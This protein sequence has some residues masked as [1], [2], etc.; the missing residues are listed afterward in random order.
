MDGRHLH[1]KCEALHSVLNDEIHNLVINEPPGSCKSML[2]NVFLPAYIWLVEDPA[3]RMLFAS[4]SKTLSDRDAGKVI[5]LLR[6]PLVKAAYPEFS[7]GPDK[8]KKAAGN[9]Y[10]DHG[11]HRFN[12]STPGGQLTGLHFHLH[13][14][15][16]PIKPESVLTGVGEEFQTAL[17][18]SMRWIGNTAGSRFIP[19]VDG[20]RI[21]MMQR[22]HDADPAGR[23]LQEG[24]W[25]HLCFPEE[26]VPG[27]KWIRGDLTTKLE[28]RT[29]PG[30][31]LWPERRDARKLARDK[32]A[33]GDAATVSAQLQQNPTPDSGGILERKWITDHAYQTPPRL[34]R[35]QLAASFDFNFK[36]KKGSGSLAK[37]RVGC[38]LWA[39]YEGIYYLIAAEALHTGY[40]GS[41]DL[42][43]RKEADE[44]WAPAT[45]LIEAKANGPAVEED[46]SEEFS[47]LRL[48]EP[49]S[50]GKADR[51]A[52]FIEPIRRGEVRFPDPKIYPWAEEVIDEIVKF[53]RAQYDE[54]WDC[55]TQGLMYLKSG[56]RNYSEGLKKLRAAGWA[57]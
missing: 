20:K 12:A 9:F 32:K 1:A 34:D 57:V 29:E 39:K 36:E 38:H 55:A 46:L 3:H 15:D 33:M 19:S 40:R 52:P 54:H 31:L 45:F 47:N 35:C 4:Y 17:N 41:K 49:G 28:W 21:L 51:M 16:D 56:A 14:Y 42:I 30:E 24:G 26:Y 48:Y 18:A 25:E 10:N 2:L 23:L 13:V 53:P 22:L 11:G 50:T 5:E 6:S 8:E 44:M 43:R 27:A 7:L 37:S